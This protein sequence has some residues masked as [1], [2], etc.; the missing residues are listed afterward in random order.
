MFPIFIQQIKKKRKTL[1]VIQIDIENVY[2]LQIKKNF[3]LNLKCLTT[4]I[5]MSSVFFH[6]TTQKCIF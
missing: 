6:N 4:G 3:L 1:F 5:H 2:S